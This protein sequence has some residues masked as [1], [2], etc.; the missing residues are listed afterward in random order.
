[1]RGLV[2]RRPAGCPARWASGRGSRGP[3][4]P[5]W[6]LAP[7]GR[8]NYGEARRAG[9]IAAT[10]I[11]RRRRPDPRPSG[12]R[13]MCPLSSGLPAEALAGGGMRSPGAAG[14]Q[15]V[16]GLSPRAAG[17]C[18]TPPRRAP[19]RLPPWRSGQ[20]R[21]RSMSAPRLAARPLQLAAAGGR[22]RARSLGAAAAPDQGRA[23]AHRTRRRNDRRRRPCLERPPS[24]RRRAPRRSVH[25]HGNL[26]PP[27]GRT[28]ERP[29]RRHRR[30]R[31]RPGLAPYR[32]RGPRCAWRP[33]RLQRL[34]ARTGGRRGP[35][36]RLPGGPS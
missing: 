25:G 6:L 3:C 27:S 2:Q 32:R 7:A 17:G 12:I 5:G 19:A 20:A 14:D 13:M 22:H 1:M 8:A 31:R 26:P 4:A 15:P 16:A 10:P 28:V 18:R 35:D 21:P 36:P 30:P 33:A 34:L 24:V 11:A 9:T 23:G 29:T